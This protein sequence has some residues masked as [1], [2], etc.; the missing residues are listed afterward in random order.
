MRLTAAARSIK[1]SHTWTGND[2]VF[3]D[4]FWMKGTRYLNSSIFT[5][6]HKIHKRQ[7]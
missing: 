1:M 2:V 3:V 5:E 7:S 6:N 4:D